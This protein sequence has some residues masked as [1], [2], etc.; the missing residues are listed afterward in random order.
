M[1]YR[2]GG[3]GGGDDSEINPLLNR[4]QT[5]GDRDDVVIHNH[6]N[7]PMSG[8]VPSPNSGIHTLL[9]DGINHTI[10]TNNSSSD[11]QLRHRHHRSSSPNNT[12][13]HQQ[14]QSWDIY[15]RHSLDDADIAGGAFRIPINNN[16]LSSSATSPAS[17]STTRSRSF[18]GSTSSSTR[19]STP[20]SNNYNDTRRQ[21]LTPLSG[22]LQ[23]S[24]EHHLIQQQHHQHQQPHSHEIDRGGRR[25]V[26]YG[27]SEHD[28]LR[29]SMHNEQ[30]RKVLPPV[31]N[32]TSDRFTTSSRF[33]ITNQSSSKTNKPQFIVLGINLT[34]YPPRFQFLLSAFG[35]FLFSL[36]YGYLQELI[37]FELCSRK[38]GLFLALMQ[39]MG[40]TILSYFFRKFGTN[41][42]DSKNTM[43]G[44]SNIDGKRRL[45]VSSGSAAMG[46]GSSSSSSQQQSMTAMIR[47]VRKR[48]QYGRT[49]TSDEDD[50]AAS[51][52][53]ST[54]VPIELYIGLSILRAIDLGMT[55]LAMQYVNYPTKTLMKSTR[56]VFTM[57]FGVVI[58]RKRYVMADYSIVMLMVVGLCMFLHADTQTSAVFAPMGILMLIIS[59]LC[60]GAISNLSE[61]LMNQYSVGQDE[62]IFRLYSIATFFIFI[63][64]AIKGDLHDGMA[65]LTRPGTIK[66]MEDGL[67]LDN[68]TSWSISGKVLTMILFSTTGY[69]SS[70][71][72]AAITKTFGAL[73]MSITSTARKATT[74]FLSFALFPSNECTVE[75]VGGILL[76]ITSLIVK[77]LRAS[78]RHASTGNYQQQHQNYRH[79]SNISS[80]IKDK[81]K[82]GNG[83][84]NVGG[85]ER[86]LELNTSPLLHYR[87]R[88]NGDDNDVV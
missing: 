42:G 35:S 79:G 68:T 10:N 23:S 88:S 25:G 46:S 54:T 20:P 72:S 76:F 19:K 52:S 22:R 64:A 51:I 2:S 69:L 39:F 60:D 34:S 81:G 86:I 77:S 9:P 31:P 8:Q 3:G 74:I 6:N 59:L 53:T 1:A 26:Y 37:S 38:L 82:G 13:Q 41:G 80:P 63:A 4:H 12:I 75:H 47:R 30:G 43:N 49:K 5:T 58:T 24:H 48:I 16:R 17:N 87:R 61:A 40:Y 32:I 15:G 21:S 78:K 28:F 71:C 73:A 55:N 29:L 14:S 18:G 62:F 85:N 33:N 11:N 45:S 7:A 50:E 83:M 27:G 56:V 36:L 70:S 65:Y 66:E 44:G 67:L 84:M 57:I